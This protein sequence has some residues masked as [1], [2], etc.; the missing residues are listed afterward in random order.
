MRYANR[1]GLFLSICAFGWGCAGDDEA[2]PA[3]DTGVASDTS[4]DASADAAIDSTI[5]AVIDS[6][7]ADSSVDG[8]ADDAD[9]L[10]DGTIGDSATT[11]T[12]AADATVDGADAKADSLLADAADAADAADTSTVVDAAADAPDAVADAP[13]DAADAADGADARDAAADAP[14]DAPADTPADAADAADAAD[15]A[16]SFGVAPLCDG[17]IVAGEYGDHTEGKNQYTST[18]QT[19]FATWDDTSLYVALTNANVAEGAVLYLEKAPLTPST[20]G[21]NADGDLAGQAYDGA[22]YASL[23]FRADLVVYA[24]SGYREYRTADGAGGWSSAVASAGCFATNG[25]TRELSIPWSAVGGRP[26][27][28]SMFA[29]TVSAS[30]YV[31]GQ[32]PTTLASGTVGS[33]ATASAYFYVSD[34]SASA[35]QKPFATVLP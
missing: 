17:I 16:A 24:K 29:Y 2:Q 19:W 10:A 12:G 23:P 18:A 21:T 32:A 26:A 13:A 31:Y 28:F 14:A 1:L 30:G 9:A 3:W 15:V 34:T 27:R 20:S 33:S 6:G 11:D 35:G 8:S 4:V 7:A 25:T 5:D 22:R